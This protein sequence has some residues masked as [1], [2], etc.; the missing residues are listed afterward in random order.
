MEGDEEPLLLG[1]MPFVQFAEWEPVEAH[2]VDRLDGEN[3]CGYRNACMVLRVG[4]RCD[5]GVMW[6]GEWDCRGET[7]VR[8]GA[9]IKNLLGRWTRRDK[10]NEKKGRNETLHQ[11]RVCVPA[12]GLEEN[13]VVVVWERERRGGEARAGA[14]TATAVRF[15][16]MVRRGWVRG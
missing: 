10:N 12:L 13:V 2:M 16:I 8:C 3:T 6:C 9:I 7:D 14:R 1:I 15:R 4:R 5:P 11:V